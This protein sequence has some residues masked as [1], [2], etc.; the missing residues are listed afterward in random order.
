MMRSE[1]VYSFLRFTASY[2]F[3]LETLDLTSVD[4]MVASSEAAD[5]EECPL[6]SGPYE[7]APRDRIFGSAIEIKNL[8]G[9]WLSPVCA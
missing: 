2:S 9:C 8:L 1:V 7:V 3:T 6:V 5:K 4:T